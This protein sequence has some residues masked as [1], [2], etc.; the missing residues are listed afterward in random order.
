MNHIPTEMPSFRRCPRDPDFWSLRVNRDIRLIVH[1]TADSL[2]ICHVDHHDEAYR[3]AQRRRIETHPRTGAAQI[4]EVRELV[5]EISIPAPVPASDEAQPQGR[6]ARLFAELT[7]DDLLAL[8]VPADWLQDVLQASEDGFLE[9]ADHLPQEA[10]EA[11]LE[12]AATGMLPKPAPTPPGVT[13]FEH[14]DALRRF[15]VMDNIEELKAALEYPL[16]RWAVFLHPSQRALVERDYNGPARVSG[17]AGTGKTVVALHRT[18]HLL[19][20]NPRARILLTTFS[21]P[22]ANAL[23]HKLHVL[24]GSMAEQVNIAPFGDV[25]RQLFALAAGHDPRIADRQRISRVLATAREDADVE[26]FAL[27]F[28][29]SEWH[30]VVDAWQ[31]TDLQQYAAVPRL[32]RYRRLGAR[33]RERLWQI[34]E[35][36]RELLRG[37]GFMTWP[38]VFAEVARHHAHADN[39]PFDH[40]I[41]DEAQDLGVPEMRMM[42]AI[43]PAG[44]NALFFAGDMGQRIFQLPFSWKALGVD[45]RGRSFVLK[46]NYRTSHQIRRT[47]DRLLPD[48]LRDV[49][50]NEEERRGTVSVFNGPEPDIRL[51]DAPREEAEAVAEWLRQ[52][53]AEGMEPEELGIFVR[54]AKQLARARQAVELAGEEW[55]ELSD[56]I[57]ERQGRIRIG[58]MHLAKGLEFRAVAVMA[59]DE[60]ILPALERLETAGDEAELDEIYETERQLLYVAT[61]RARERLLVTGVLPGSEFLEDLQQKT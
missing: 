5:E 39:K 29:E 14:P 15:R 58:T 26:G 56:R 9:L 60:D 54:Q 38:E 10:A 24:L 20:S 37:D 46:V 25:A 22:L 57:E 13:P 44:T 21:H 3:W 41:V 48:S 6:G 50:G 47:A 42:A 28:I 18:A 7:E 36:A 59:C 16:E 30:A 19:R 32:G 61:T 45:V 17:S 12:Y 33:Q 1:K 40:V 31:I 53:R 23:K 35:R 4:V 2:L 51:F 49:D 8:G 27:R 43:A 34:F 52:T 55:L 11:L